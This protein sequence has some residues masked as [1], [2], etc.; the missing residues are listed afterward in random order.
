MV[1]KLFCGRKP[2]ADC[3]LLDPGCGEGEFIAGVLRFCVSKNWPI[4]QIVGVEIDVTRADSARQSFRDI[5]RVTVRHAD[6]LLAL[7]ES[8]DFIIGN[9]PYVSILDLS[10]EQRLSYKSSFRTASG[11]F[12]L[13][14]PF[15]EKALR[16]LCL[17]GKLVFITPEKFLYVVRMQ[18]CRAG[19]VPRARTRSYCSCCRHL[20]ASVELGF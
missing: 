15:F 2:S 11:R 5:R 10:P 6:Y 16:M 9:P 4:P 18:A 8:F 17:E 19:N 13:Y 1:A 12:D 14:M 7:P 3:R 20:D